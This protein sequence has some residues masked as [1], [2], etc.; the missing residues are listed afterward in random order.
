MSH[1]QINHPSLSERVLHAIR[2]MREAWELNSLTCD[3][4][5]ALA[6]DAGISSHDLRDAVMA[7]DDAFKRYLAM[8]D[9]HGVSADNRINLADPMMRDVVRVCQN[10]ANKNH[11][12]DELEAGTA[13]A[14]A[15][16]FCP[17]APIFS[18]LAERMNSLFHR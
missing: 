11:C 12:D 3:Q 5:E 17:N 7:G 18:H 9:Q 16:Q 15:G 8:M 1:S 2:R 14:H 13:G 10:C 6:R 4:V